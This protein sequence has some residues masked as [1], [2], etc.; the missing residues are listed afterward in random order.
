MQDVVWNCTCCS[1]RRTKRLVEGINLFKGNVDGIICTVRDNLDKYL[2]FAN[3]LTKT[4]TLH[5]KT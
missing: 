5:K 3:S 4:C 1:H 2:K